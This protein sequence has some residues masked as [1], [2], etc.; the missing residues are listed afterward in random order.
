MEINRVVYA[1]TRI[2]CTRVHGPTRVPTYYNYIYLYTAV[3]GQTENCHRSYRYYI[4]Y[5]P[6]YYTSGC[7]FLQISRDKRNSRFLHFP[8]RFSVTLNPELFLY[9]YIYQLYNSINSCT[10]HRTVTYKYRALICFLRSSVENSP[11]DEEQ[12]CRQLL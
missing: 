2:S 3:D 10:V 8:I 12:L 6:L 11:A 9:G 1:E 7:W 4:I 5:A